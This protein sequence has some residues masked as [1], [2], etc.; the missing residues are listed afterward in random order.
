[1][2]RCIFDVPSSTDLI[3]VTEST[4]CWYLFDTRQRA[5]PQPAAFLTDQCTC[6]MPSTYIYTSF[7]SNSVLAKSVAV[8]KMPKLYYSIACYVGRILRGHVAI[9]SKLESTLY[10]LTGSTISG[11]WCCIGPSPKFSL[12]LWLG[13]GLGIGE[14]RHDVAV[15]YGTMYL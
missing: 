7:V 15:I 13:V 14:A 8:S 10:V 3:L 12:Q 5:C 11:T 1:M 6:I 2:I 9:I 4:I